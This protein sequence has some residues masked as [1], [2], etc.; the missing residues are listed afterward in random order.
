MTTSINRPMNAREW[1]L[2]LALTLLWGGSFFF[3][4]VAVTELPPF[5]LVLARVGLAALILQGALVVLGR[6]PPWRHWRAFLVMGLLNN[7]LPFSLIVW[8]QTTIAS[9]LAAILNAT[10]P[11][12]TVLLAHAVTADEKLSGPRL[13]GCALG[14][15]GVA[16]MLGP[17][18]GE[19]GGNLWPQLAVLAAALSYACAGVWGRRFA[20]L[21]LA[22]VE[23]ATG[24]VT[25]STLLLL[26]LVLLADR[27]WTLAP[28][29]AETWA[30]IAGLALLSTAL[31]YVVYFRLLASAGA[32]NLLLV[33]LLMPPL[34]VWLG[35]VFLG[36]SLGIVHL[37]GLALIAAGLVAIDGRLL[38]ILKK[39]RRHYSRPK[40]STAV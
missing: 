32:T 22:P 11:L 20:A 7:A 33:T 23:T 19:L 2:L 14:L 12:F 6:R 39:G 35:F 15:A 4:G 29:G 13:L 24:Q 9:G 16:L 3:T 5:S 10:T 25:A 36:E 21:G 34:A 37:A 40:G 27:P 8:G 17:D 38:A 28:P 1:P 31:G 30:A 26:P 18:V